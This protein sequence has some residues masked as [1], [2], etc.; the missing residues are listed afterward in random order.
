LRGSYASSPW[1]GVASAGGFSSTKSASEGTNPPS[2]GAA[3]NGITPAQFDGVNDTLTLTGTLAD[4]VSASAYSGW[5][6]ALANR[7]T[8]ANVDGFNNNVIISNST[9]AAFAVGMRSSGKVVLYHLDTTAKNAEAHFT[10][11]AWQFVH[12]R[13]DGRKICIGVNG[14]WGT[15]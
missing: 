7:V 11:G 2:A 10:I 4:Y 12:W 15:P 3:V 5:A 13:F 9:S 6:L 14:T 1:T 8:T